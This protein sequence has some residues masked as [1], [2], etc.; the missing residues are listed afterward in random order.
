MTKAATVK[1]VLALAILLAG[2]T[3][4]S[5]RVFAQEGGHNG[6]PGH[7]P[8]HPPIGGE[9]VAID[10]DSITITLPGDIHFPNQ[11]MD[12]LGLEEGEEL[13]FIINDETEIRSEDDT[14]EAG[15]TVFIAV[16]RANDS[17]Y[18]RVISDKAPP[19]RGH[20]G[21]VISIDTETN[22][23]VLEN[24]QGEQRTVQYSDDTIFRELRQEASEEDVEVGDHLMIHGWYD[25][26]NE[27]GE[28][29]AI[30][31]MEPINWS[32]VGPKQI[33]QN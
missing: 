10:D 23:I 22:E 25:Q 24:P 8:G 11:L 5:V 7:R 2:L 12:E 28:I 19:R 1:S 31:I 13:T 33:E 29:K 9:V 26:E 16:F 21:A 17:L 6:P 30:H 32:E 15:D 4:G 18:A 27:T 14:V 20:V 3:A